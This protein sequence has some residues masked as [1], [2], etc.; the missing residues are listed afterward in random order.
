MP[1]FSPTIALVA[2]CSRLSVVVHANAPHGRGPAER[3]MSCAAGYLAGQAAA[4]VGCESVRTRPM[5]KVVRGLRDSS[6]RV[7]SRPSGVHQ[8]FLRRSTTPGVVDR[9]KKVSG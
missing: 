5:T 9:R 4:D 2:I 8:P 7:P 3:W 1:T 6:G